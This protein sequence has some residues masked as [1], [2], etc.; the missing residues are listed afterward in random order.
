MSEMRSVGFAILGA[1]GYMGT[2]AIEAL[3]LVREKLIHEGIRVQLLF[4]IDTN[5]WNES[6][7]NEPWTPLLHHYYNRLQIRPV[8]SFG[9]E[10]LFDA[11]GFL[12]K[13]VESHNPLVVYDAT[14]TGAHFG[15]LSWVLAR[16]PD[17][18]AYIG[19]K[20]LFVDPSEI[21]EMKNNFSLDCR[22]YC[23]FIET[24]NPVFSA[25]RSEIERLHL[26]ID[27]MWFWRAG[28]SGIK[29]LIGADR[30]GVGGGA[31]LDKAPHDLSL[32]VGLLGPTEIASKK[33]VSATVPCHALSR[34]AVTEGF[35]AFL[36]ATGRSTPSLEKGY[37]LDSQF[38]Q[39]AAFPADALFESDIEWILRGG[40]H[41]PV[42]YL[43]SWLGYNGVRVDLEKISSDQIPST[44]FSHEPMA[45]FPAEQ[46]FWELLDQ[47]GFGDPLG[48][49]E[50][51]PWLMLRP[52]LGPCSF[53]G[54]PD[55]GSTHTGATHLM[56]ES[57]V[58]I[59]V[60]RCSDRTFIC[61]F[62]SNT[63]DYSEDRAFTRY[64]YVIEDCG[65]RYCLDLNSQVGRVGESYRDVK[66][67]DLA[68]IF[69]RVIRDKLEGKEHA[70]LC[71]K[72]AIYHTHE[73]LLEAQDLARDDLIRRLQEAGDRHDF[74]DAELSNAHS[75]F[76]SY[77]KPLHGLRSR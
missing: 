31:L 1:C 73:A 15:N 47:L 7:P 55:F 72:D 44:G 5:L 65:K 75:R 58:R 3:K 59:A 46:R 74:N 11:T 48:G 28:A 40:K 39:R 18:I 60:I 64:A 52:V 62:L 38:P 53:A 12:Y 70:A 13:K 45:A 54:P 9:L 25:V 37:Q 29:K 23:N 49:P 21:I 35:N 63:D 50:S 68:V 43:F 33:V 22:F 20:P 71:S 8:I 67:R 61:N 34:L 4:A 19:E 76:M 26:E 10:N 36:T 77:I 51:H 41:V 24:T 27:E 66:G 56:V 16:N 2:T 30:A 32:T 17:D 42:H 69:E 6:N 14:P 57:Q